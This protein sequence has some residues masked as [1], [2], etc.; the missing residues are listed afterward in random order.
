MAE[1]RQIQQRYLE[2]QL[3]IAH[4][5]QLCDVQSDS[6]MDLSLRMVSDDDCIPCATLHHPLSDSLDMEEGWR[7]LCRSWDIACFRYHPASSRYA[8]GNNRLC[9]FNTSG[10]GGT[11]RDY[12]DNHCGIYFHETRIRNCQSRECQK[13][14]QTAS[15]N[16]QVY[17]LFR[18]SCFDAQPATFND[19]LFWKQQ[20]GVGIHDEYYQWKHSMP[21]HSSNRNL[22]DPIWED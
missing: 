7:G 17:N 9:L 22:N 13:G 14:Q 8:D 10:S 3:F 6:G 16:N 12:H 2:N 1:E 19:S 21:F 11:W 18:G 20:S 15:P 5:Y 4:Q